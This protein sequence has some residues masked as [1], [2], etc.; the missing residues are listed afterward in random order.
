MV[1]GS[2][3]RLETIPPHSCRPFWRHLSQPL[4]NSFCYARFCRVRE[5]MQECG[6]AHIESDAPDA[7]KA[8]IR[9][10][11]LAFAR[12]DNVEEFRFPSDLAEIEAMSW[13]QMTFLAASLTAT[14]LEEEHGVVAVVEGNGSPK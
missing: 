1:A 2:S 11:E 5:A 14:V 7:W 10:L 8:G 6:S 9:A 3:V 13:K 4:V 12:T